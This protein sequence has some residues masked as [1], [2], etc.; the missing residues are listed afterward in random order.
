MNIQQAITKSQI[1]RGAGALLL[2]GG[3]LFYVV[4]VL[5]AIY[6]TAQSWNGNPLLWRLGSAIQ[7]LI[8][9]VYQ[10][11]SPYIDFVWRNVPTLDQED[12][13]TY[14]NLLFL[15]LL[16]V[17]IVGKQLVLYG[18]RLRAR[19]QRQIDRVEDQQWRSSMTLNNTPSGTA[20]AATTIGQ[21]NLHQH[22]MPPSPD[23]DWW[24]R[25]WGMLGLSII[26][27]YIVAVI[28]KLTGML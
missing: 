8:A 21:M 16:G 5:M 18:R 19:I 11:T 23:G 10:M 3:T 13:F 14:G 24:T 12:P 22:T 7:D 4:S 9:S 17:M 25:P 27:G 6:R 1:Q 2:F 28:A 26:S 15:G 20:I